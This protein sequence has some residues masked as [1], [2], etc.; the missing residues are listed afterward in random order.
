MEAA[1]SRGH[2]RSNS[3]I[4]LQKQF[5][6]GRPV[7][8]IQD[9]GDSERLLGNKR[10]LDATAQALLKRGIAPTQDGWGG[11]LG[12]YQGVIANAAESIQKARSAHC[13][14]RE[15]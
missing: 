11:W 1:R 2:L 4:R 5:V 6:N 3:F 14:S 9:M 15:R 8:E 10:Y 12:R 13:E 7:L